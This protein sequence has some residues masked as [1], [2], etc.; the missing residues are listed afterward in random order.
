MTLLSTQLQMV[1]YPTHLRRDLQS[2]IRLS[3]AKIPFSGVQQ[4]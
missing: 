4:F 1:V 3:M 2:F